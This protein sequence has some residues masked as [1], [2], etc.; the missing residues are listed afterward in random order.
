MQQRNRQEN[1]VD[2][3]GPDENTPFHSAETSVTRRRNRT[4][5]TS[6]DHMMQGNQS[7]TDDAESEIEIVSVQKNKRVRLS[8]KSKQVLRSSFSNAEDGLDVVDEKHI[9]PQERLRRIQEQHARGEV[10]RING[11]EEPRSFPLFGLDSRQGVTGPR[12]FHPYLMPPPPR[13]E[14]YD[15]ILGGAIPFR[16]M[17]TNMGYNSEQIVMERALQA[18][19][20]ETS[21][22][23]LDPSSL[24]LPMVPLTDARHGFT[25]SLNVEGD[26]VCIRCGHILGTCGEGLTGSAKIRSQQVF[27]RGCGHVYCGHCTFAMKDRANKKKAC[28]I[29]ECKSVNPK[30]RGLFREVFL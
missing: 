16:V 15:F 19:M 25:R 23:S 30:K 17:N 28:P 1:F 11:N 10:V 2:L 27:A 14:G 24:M 29:A 13:L 4:N 8:R 7:N 26:L 21:G 18:S 20:D 22:K 6:E 12:A 9:T 3:T 5:A